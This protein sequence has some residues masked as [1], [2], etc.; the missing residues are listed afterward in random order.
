MNKQWTDSEIID[1]YDS[2]LNITLRELAV[3]TG[4]TVQQLKSLLMGA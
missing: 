3:L 2:N 1:Y 4:R